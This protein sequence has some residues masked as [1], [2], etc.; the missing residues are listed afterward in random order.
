MPFYCAAP[1]STV[2]PRTPEG[3]S[4]PIEERHQSEVRGFLAAQAAAPAAQVW[5][6]A[7]DVTPAALVTAFITDIGIVRPGEIRARFQPS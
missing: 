5:N 1:S 7:F 2:D 3:R 6:P 4:I